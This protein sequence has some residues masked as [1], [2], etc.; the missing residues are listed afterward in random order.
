MMSYRDKKTIQSEPW[1]CQASGCVYYRVTEA[2][3]DR[4]NPNPNR[5]EVLSQPSMDACFKKTDIFVKM[6]QC[7]R[8]Y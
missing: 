1:R 8:L 2:G 4:A 5:T 7:L 3:E 6:A